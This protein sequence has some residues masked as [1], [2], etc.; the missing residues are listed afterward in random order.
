VPLYGLFLLWPVAVILLELLDIVE[1]CYRICSEQRKESTE[2]DDDDGG[3]GGVKASAMRRLRKLL[4]LGH[5][6]MFGFHYLS[7]ISALAFS[8]TVIAWSAH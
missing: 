7:N 5:V 1:F 2:S 6:L 3:G 4:A 8:S